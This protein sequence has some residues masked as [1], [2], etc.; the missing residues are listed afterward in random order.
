VEYEYADDSTAAAAGAAEAA[1]LTPDSL[2]SLPRQLI[3]SMREA[4]VTA[5]LDQLLAKIQ[6]VESHDAHVAQGLRRLAEGFQYEKLLEL[7][8]AGARIESGN[9]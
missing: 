6:E 9:D 2:A 3:D 7:L 8:T 1:E 5:D 4:V